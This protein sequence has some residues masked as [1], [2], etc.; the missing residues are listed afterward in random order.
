MVGFMSSEEEEEEEEEGLRIVLSP[1][2]L[3][4]ILHNASISEGETL[5]NRLWGGLS[6]TGGMH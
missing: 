1:V 2:Q 4:G 5:T 3:A 6:L